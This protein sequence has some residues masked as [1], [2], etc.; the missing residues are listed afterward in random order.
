MTEWIFKYVEFTNSSGLHLTCSIHTAKVSSG[1]SHVTPPFER[2]GSLWTC[3]S[4]LRIRDAI[5]Y[6]NAC[7]WNNNHARTY[8]SWH[9]FLCSSPRNISHTLI[10]LGNAVHA[11]G[12]FYFLFYRIVFAILPVPRQTAKLLTVEISTLPFY[13][14]CSTHIFVALGS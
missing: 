6:E 4:H 13:K 1:V 10:Q 11:K 14:I 2:N 8:C 5:D 9:C 7:C 12:L 3:P